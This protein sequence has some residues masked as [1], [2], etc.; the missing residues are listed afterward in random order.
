MMCNYEL[1]RSLPDFVSYQVTFTVSN[2]RMTRSTPRWPALM[3][4]LGWSISRISFAKYVRHLADISYPVYKPESGLDVGLQHSVLHGSRTF[5]LTLCNGWGSL[6]SHPWPPL[7]PIMSLWL[8]LDL[9][10]THWWKKPSFFYY[11]FGVFV[12]LFIF[13]FFWPRVFMAKSMPWSE[14]PPNDPWTLV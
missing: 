4:S 13:F 8:T 9:M 6:Q 3:H 7:I 1:S 12:C 11:Y 10:L 14:S 5:L 2:W